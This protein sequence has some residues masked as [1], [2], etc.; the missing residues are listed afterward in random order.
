MNSNTA[1][2]GFSILSQQY[3]GKQILDGQDG[4]I[5]RIMIGVYLPSGGTTG[6]FSISW[7]KLAG[8]ST[9]KLEAFDYAWLVMSQMP[10]LVGVLTTL[11][12]EKPT[13]EQVADIL[14]SLGYKDRTERESAEHGQKPV[15]MIPVPNV[16]W[17]SNV[18]RAADG[19]NRLGAGELA[20]RI[21]EELE[22][23]GGKA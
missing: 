20:E 5:D 21:V 10:E 13:P 19:E 22:K 2:K 8:E 6:E 7:S 11:D 12:S 15:R 18:I 14:R 23:T 3:Y 16:D 17:L 9:P 4:L 1:H